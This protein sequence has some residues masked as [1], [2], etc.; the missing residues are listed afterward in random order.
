MDSEETKKDDAAQE[1]NI[2]Y[3][4]PKVFCPWCRGQDVAFLG[5]ESE[6]DRSWFKCLVCPHD[7]RV[8]SLKLID[9]PRYTYQAK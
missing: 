5:N 3:W 4:G 2:G 9:K 8:F 1:L 6:T 7:R